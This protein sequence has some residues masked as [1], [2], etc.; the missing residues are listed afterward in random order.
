MNRT[1]TKIAGLSMLAL[2]SAAKAGQ[3]PADGSNGDNQYGGVASITL[4]PNRVSFVL[5]EDAINS[6]GGGSLL[7]LVKQLLERYAPSLCSDI[8]DFEQPHKDLT[9]GVAVISP[10]SGTS[11][12]VVGK[13]R[14]ITFDYVPSRN[15]RCNMPEPPGHN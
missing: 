13:E 11:L 12:Y 3:P 4:N 1:A 7:E 10:A 15:V 8:L 6:A 2:A 14:S 9:V 5:K